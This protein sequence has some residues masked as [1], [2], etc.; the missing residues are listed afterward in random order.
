MICK[1]G[2]GIMSIEESCQD[3]ECEGKLVYAEGE[4]CPICEKPLPTCEAKRER[5]EQM[6]IDGCVSQGPVILSYCSGLCESNSTALMGPPFIEM[7]CHCCKP[8]AWYNT[9]MTFECED[10]TQNF[11]RE[12]FIIE[13][14]DC[15]SCGFDPR[16]SA[17]MVPVAAATATAN[18]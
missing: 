14:C 12:Y 3:L 6:V 9:T 4:C 16:E 17:S 11:Q 18:P 8:T 15:E 10:A 2:V 5:Q 1:E 13:E 7:N